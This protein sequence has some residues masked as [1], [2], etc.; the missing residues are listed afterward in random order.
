MYFVVDS[1]ARV[2]HFWVYSMEMSK[3]PLLGLILE[4]TT[5]AGA[6]ILS[7]GS[8]LYVSHNKRLAKMVP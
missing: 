6:V 4:E 2:A 1:P 3:D 5:T 8:F 7:D